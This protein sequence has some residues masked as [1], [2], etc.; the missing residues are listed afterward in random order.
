[1]P[2]DLKPYVVKPWGR[3]ATFGLGLVAM[4]ASQI[5]ALIVLAWWLGAPL[6]KMPDFSGDGAAVALIIFVSTPIQLLLLASFAQRRG[7]N[8]AGYLGLTLPRRSE[9]VFGVVAVVAM[10]IAGNAVSWLLGINIITS[11]QSDIFRTASAAG[12]LP[13]LLL[14]A[15][16]V[17]LTPIG[18][19]TLFRGF[20]YRGWMQ[21]PRD[22][23]AV[24]VVTSLLWAL[25]HVQYD[26]YVTG[27]IFAF[28]LLLGWV[29]WC[30]GSTIL[31]ILLHALINMEGM[32]ETFVAHNWLS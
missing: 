5:V 29:R 28:G 21:K 7:G 12:L 3:L 32:L 13:L 8:A 1:V 16:V 15:A 31:T 27:Q 14:L 20:L 26:W 11:F 24:I 25:I 2:D 6:A 17:V 23:W 10:I 30:T 19:E 9:V 4:L 18:E 22:A